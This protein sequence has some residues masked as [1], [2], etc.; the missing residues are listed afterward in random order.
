MIDNMWCY[1]KVLEGIWKTFEDF[2]KYLQTFGGSIFHFTNTKWNLLY[3]Y[4]VEL[5]LQMQS[6]M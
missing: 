2:C 1:L 3:K 6:K 4:K 5:A